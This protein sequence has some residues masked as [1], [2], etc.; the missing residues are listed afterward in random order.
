MVNQLF[1]AINKKKLKEFL[2]E[3]NIPLD[4]CIAIAKNY[5][6]I[7]IQS[8]EKLF[9][10]YDSAKDAAIKAFSLLR[11]LEKENGNST[12]KNIPEGE[13]VDESQNTQSN[14]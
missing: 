10:Q 5:L 1:I 8:Q 4:A 2:Q 14:N 3:K 6:Y 12:A 11:I 13:K 7:K 9:K